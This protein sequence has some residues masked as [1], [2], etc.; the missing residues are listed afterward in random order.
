MKL[1]YL[2]I[3]ILFINKYCLSHKEEKFKPSS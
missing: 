1:E 3:V 2:A